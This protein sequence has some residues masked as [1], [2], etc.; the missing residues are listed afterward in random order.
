MAT[1]VRLEPPSAVEGKA[2]FEAAVEI[3]P[4]EDEAAEMLKSSLR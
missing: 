2:L 1:L 3:E 4:S